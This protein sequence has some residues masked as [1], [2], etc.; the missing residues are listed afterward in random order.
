MIP[1]FTFV[2]GWLAWRRR[3]IAAVSVLAAY[4]LER[5]LYVLGWHLWDRAR[6]TLI[7]EGL[8]APP[9]HSFPS[10]HAALSAAGYGLLAWLWFSRSRSWI[11]R[12][13]VVLLLIA[14]LTV[15]GV[16]RLR[17]GSHWPSDVIAGTILGLTWAAV[18]ALALHRAEATGGP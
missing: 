6:P 3:P 15:V 8:A 12:T 17:L 1:L 9:L 18:V 11:E 4:W 13:V 2:A 16:A 10:G 7:A 5:P 14:L